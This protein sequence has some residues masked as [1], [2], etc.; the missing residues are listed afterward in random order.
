MATPPS[1]PLTAGP[2]EGPESPYPLRVSGK[3]VAGFGRGSKELGI[4]TANIPVSGLSVGGHEEIESGIYF[5]LAS[6]KEDNKEVEIYQ[7]VMS[8]GWNPYYKNT[9]RSV[10]V[11][12]LH[13]FPYDFYGAHMKL[14]ILGYIRPERDYDSKD[15]LIADIKEDAEVAKRSLA[16]GPYSAFTEESWLRAEGGWE[17]V[18]S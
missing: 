8:I 12:L 9:N 16:R 13:T 15:A 7:M 11:H 2:A 3:V 18:G 1:R 4:P 10:E 14:L 6:L 17:E 5:G